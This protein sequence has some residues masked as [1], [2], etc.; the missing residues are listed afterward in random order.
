MPM[1]TLKKFNNDGIKEFSD[2][3]ENTRKNENKTNVKSKIPPLTTNHNLVID[4]DVKCQIEDDKLFHDRYEMGKYLNKMLKNHADDYNN[5]GMWSWLAAVYFDQLRGKRT[6]RSEHFIPDEYKSGGITST[7]SAHYRH[8]VRMPVY[9]IKYY[10]DEW[11]KFLLKDKLDTMGDPMEHCCS[12]R[13]NLKS[14]K[15]RSVILEL[16]QDKTTFLPKSGAFSRVNKNNLKSLA[17]KGGVLRFN[18]TL[19]DRLKK[20]YDIENMDVKTI[21][22][23]MGPEVKSSKWVK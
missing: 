5:F 18:G 4:V 11:C 3:L 13:A 15:L 14:S 20:S 9:L 22:S 8:A 7:V 12:N 1:I 23:K 21:I 2:F 19:R 17:G 16:Y 10:E 6:Q